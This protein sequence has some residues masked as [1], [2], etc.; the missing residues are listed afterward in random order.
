M[1]IIKK[2]NIAEFKAHMGVHLKRVRGGEE[3]ILKDRNMEIAKISPVTNEVKTPFK[4]TRAKRSPKEFD[5]FV[6]PQLNLGGLDSLQLLK[7]LRA[8]KK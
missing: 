8:D 4:I 6:S 1:A 3:V 2:V 7:E 5:A